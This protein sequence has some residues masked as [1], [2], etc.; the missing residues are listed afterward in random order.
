MPSTLVICFQYAICMS[1]ISSL[2]PY[3]YLPQKFVM[4]KTP[5]Y[6]AFVTSHQVISSV[7]K[8]RTLYSTELIVINVKFLHNNYYDFIYYF[9]LS[10]YVEIHIRC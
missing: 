5:C 7:L 8:N 2:A 9:I 3:S 6:S 1:T 4:K 10:W